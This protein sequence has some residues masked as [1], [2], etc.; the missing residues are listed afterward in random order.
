MLNQDLAAKQNSDNRL[1]M[2][3]RIAEKN[4]PE[5]PEEAL[6]FI[7]KAFLWRQQAKKTKQEIE[8][9]SKKGNIYWYTNKYSEAL[10]AYFKSLEL[11]VL[12]KD[13]KEEAKAQPARKIDIV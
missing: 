3:I 9:Y 12:S 11:G 10:N 13:K 7:D 6:E 5:A 8:C 1:S 4:M 2:L